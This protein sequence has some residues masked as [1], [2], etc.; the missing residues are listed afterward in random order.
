MYRY[1]TQ[2]G[3]EYRI[4]PG[5]RMASKEEHRKYI[6]RLLY[7]DVGRR[8]AEIARKHEA[9]ETVWK[10]EEEI[11]HDPADVLRK[12]DEERDFKPNDIITLRLTVEVRTHDP[13]NEHSE[14]RR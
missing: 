1:S 3:H 2:L 10:F 13:I 4:P 5:G 11:I 8:L 14:A 7:E 6:K 9:M 12:L